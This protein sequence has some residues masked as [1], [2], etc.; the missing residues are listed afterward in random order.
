MTFPLMTSGILRYDS[1]DPGNTLSMLYFTNSLG[2]A[3]GV[4]ASGY[5]LIRLIGLPGT[6]M[7]AG[8]NNIAI[9]LAV[10]LLMG[11]R[12]R[13]T[14][15]QL[16]LVPRTASG[17]SCFWRSHFSRAW[18]RSSMKRMDQ[19]AE[20]CSGK[21]HHAF[22]LMLSA[23][24]L[25]LPSAAFDPASSTGRR[26]RSGFRRVQILGILATATLPFMET[27]S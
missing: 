6:I 22:E 17:C 2:A 10:W 18:R 3:V 27:P 13:P 14:V 24:I 23:F 15:R 1:R 9:A 5:L 19:D 11:K 16:R 4:I 8:L 25:D 21:F 7:I 12:V 20:L 26:T